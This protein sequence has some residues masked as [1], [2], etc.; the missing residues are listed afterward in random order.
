MRIVDFYR[1]KQPDSEGR[2]LNDILG[3]DDARLEYA[4][5][6][7]QWLFPLTTPS[8]FNPDAPLL[9]DV[10]IEVFRTDPTHAVP[11]RLAELWSDVR[12][13]LDE[14]PVSAVAIE[15]VLFQVNVRTAMSVGQA[16]GVVMAEAASRGLSVREYSPNEVKD[17][18]RA[19][20]TA[21]V[22][23]ASSSACDSDRAAF[24]D[25]I[26][27][28][29]PNLQASDVRTGCPGGQMTAGF[30]AQAG[31]A[32]PGWRRSAQRWRAEPTRQAR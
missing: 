28:P 27:T 2:F 14:F 5:D 26:S 18:V 32:C 22:I 20:I 12:G 9:D 15:R 21:R 10:Q 17:A 3:W 13:L 16:S 25:D 8:Q 30:Q 29:L 19:A 23:R 7:I 6:Y 11:D 4:H 31:G 1:N 24:D